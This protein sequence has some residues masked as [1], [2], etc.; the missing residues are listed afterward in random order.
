MKGV[1]L[2][3]KLIIL[4]ISII[5]I[6][7]LSFQSSAF[8]PIVNEQNL[9]AELIKYAEP[10]K[11]IYVDD[12]NTQ[13]PWYGTLE[14]P[15]RTI[16]DGVNNASE[17]DTVFVFNGFYSQEHVYVRKTIK[18]IGEDKYNTILSGPS[19]AIELS[20]VIG[21]F[22]LSNF[23]FLNINAIYLYHS[24]YCIINNNIIKNSSRG[25]WLA[26]CSNC[27][28]SNNEIRV[29]WDSIVLRHSKNSKINN[30][31]VYGFN[32]SLSGISIS[33]NSDDNI[34]SNNT[35]N[36]CEDGIDV[37]ISNRVTITD[38]NIINSTRFGITFSA[39]SNS[40]IYQNKITNNN[41]C[42][43]DVSYSDDVIISDNI[44]IDNVWEGISLSYGK[45]IDVSR[46]I[47]DNSSYGIEFCFIEN[48]ICSNNTVTNISEIGIHIMDS[49][50]GNNL[51]SYNNVNKCYF[52]IF[53][54]QSWKNT[55]KNNIV[56]YNE[57]GIMLYGKAY[58]N[59]VTK[60]E[61]GKN[62]VG[63]ELYGFIQNS[64]KY[65]PFE[66]WV[67]G[68]NIRENTNCGI[69]ATILTSSNHIYYNNFIDNYQ[70]AEDRGNNKWYKLKITGSVG[71][72]WSDYTDKYPDAE[73][74][75]GVWDTPYDIPPPWRFNKDRYPSVN[76]FDIENIQV[77]GV[78]VNNYT[79]S[80]L[81]QITQQYII[82]SEI[83]FIN[84][85]S[86]LNI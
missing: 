52:G 7:I 36:N 43:V 16:I 55:Y 15:Y 73:P 79:I 6:I 4:L 72:Y 9:D 25:I 54:D 30:N 13:G 17:D 59:V 83:V 60:N 40:T 33:S 22:E 65:D 42:G 10:F 66:N 35:I 57:F 70:N 78:N 31:Y 45:N 75:N 51:V 76:P 29:R 67:V 49:R 81:Q 2:K 24:S 46:N 37:Y 21:G 8:K 58:F 27:T 85:C 48:S 18:I 61:V 84:S 23:M 39:S 53:L 71:N 82:D 12:D 38:N 32:E 47:I 80:E 56:N 1:Y 5:F 14:H 50:G 11:T 28:V 68:N 20:R 86:Y 64:R 44:I 34:I 41:N 69:Y 63:V 3:K 19:S 62:S 74:L 26:N 77:Q